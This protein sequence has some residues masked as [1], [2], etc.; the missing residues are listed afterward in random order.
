MNMILWFAAGWWVGSRQALGQA[1]VP[2]Q[3]QQDLT[4]IA[5]GTLNTSGPGQTP[6]TQPIITAKPA[7]GMGRYGRYPFR[8]YGY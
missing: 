6:N 7:A 2:P 1:I 4:A 3:V 5:S 8:T